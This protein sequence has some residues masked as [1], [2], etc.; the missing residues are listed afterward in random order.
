MH[1]A[2]SRHHGGF[3]VALKAREEADRTVMLLTGPFAFLAQ[4]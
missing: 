1:S 4:V 3:F 2:T